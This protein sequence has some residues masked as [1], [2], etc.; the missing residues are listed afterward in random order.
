VCCPRR[1][2][3]PTPCPDTARVLLGTFGHP[4]RMSRP[5][6]PADHENETE[7]TRSNA[8]FSHRTRANPRPSAPHVRNSRNSRSTKRGSPP[9]SVRSAASRKKVSRSRGRRD[10]GWCPPHPGADTS[11]RPRSRRQRGACRPRVGAK[12]GAPDLDGPAPC[13]GDPETRRCRQNQTWRHQGRRTRRT[14]ARRCLSADRFRR[15]HRAWAEPST[16]PWRASAR[17]AT[18]PRCCRAA[19]PPADRP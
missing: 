4:C 17:A 6:R 5:Q 12:D 14:A 1:S 16:C 2:Q 15:R 13:N 11:R 18:S 7:N 8:Q 3:V 10:G 9:P 19:A